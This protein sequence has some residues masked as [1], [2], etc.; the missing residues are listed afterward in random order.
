MRTTKDYFLLLV[1]G[2]SMG[3]ADVVPGVSG[4][5]VAFITGI[6]EELIQSIKSIDMNAIKLLLRFRIAEFWKQINGNFLITLVT[7][8]L[9]SLLSLSKLMLY[10]LEHHPISIWSFFFGLIL[11]STPL[12]LR[13]IKKWNAGT[14]LSFIAG[15]VIAYWIT[16]VS[17][18]ETPSNLFFIFC[19]GAIAICAMILPGISGAFILLLLGKYEYM[20]TALTEFN[21]PVIMVFVAGCVLGLLGFSHFLNWILKNYRYAT[22]AVLAGFMLGSLN[23]VWPWKQVVS[24]RLNSAGEQVPAFDKSI[25]PW[26]YLANTGQDPQILKAIL[27]VM[28]GII[29]V[30]GIEKTAAYLKSKP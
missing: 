25:A 29:L 3:G 6:Y 18:A 1:K 13:D 22:L 17:P 27:F 2:V 28:L 8:I 15:V 14:V 20:I 7:G 30:I 9:I 4:G 12:I 16:I 26:D 19:C 24:F 23:K 10:L 21:I 11:I 5:T